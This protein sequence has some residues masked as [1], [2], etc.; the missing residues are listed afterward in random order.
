M[1]EKAEWEKAIDIDGRALVL[2]EVASTQDAAVKHNLGAGD[3]C[4]ALAQSAGRGR[5]NSHWDA[6]GGVAVTVVLEQPPAHFS[7]SVA[8]TLASHLNNLVPTCKIGIKWPN[9][10]FINGRKLAGILVE[11][12]NGLCLVG[13]GVNVL[14]APPDQSATCLYEFGFNDLRAVVAQS[15]VASVFSAVDLDEHVAVLAWRDR[16]IL[17]G[18]NQRILTGGNEVEGIVRN[19]DPCNN[20]QLETKEGLLVLP[21]DISTIVTHCSTTT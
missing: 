15:V 1:N 17:L 18:T 6:S 3:V 13:V 7:I 10:L 5:R 4:A 20:L 19:I 8:A 21:A 9:D 11:Q 12:C 14:E 16:D 2:E